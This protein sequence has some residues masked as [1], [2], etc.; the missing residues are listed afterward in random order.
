MSN[1]NNDAKKVLPSLDNPFAEVR[2]V[3]FIVPGQVPGTAPGLYEHTLKAGYD[4]IQRPRTAAGVI[5]IEKQ[6]LKKRLLE[7]LKLQNKNISITV[8]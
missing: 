5:S 6:H 7:P 2:D 3:E 1:A 8:F 4:L